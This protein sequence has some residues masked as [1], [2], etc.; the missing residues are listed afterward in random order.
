MGHKRG[1]DASRTPKDEQR[2]PP[3]LFRKLDEMFHFDIDV[4]ATKE[5][6]LCSLYYT[7]ETN[8]L[9][10]PWTFIHWPD[11]YPS[12]DPQVPANPVINAFCNPPYSNG[13]VE[14]FLEKG[15]ME[16]LKGAIVVFLTTSD[17]SPA[18]YDI[19]ALAAEWIAIKGRIEFWHED[20][21]PI[22]GSSMFGSNL[23]V[24]DQEQKV[25]Q[26]GETIVTRMGWK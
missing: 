26:G 24:F 9:Q 25:K 1:L 12:S 21:T 18:Y 5:N 7:K 10:Q 15:Y 8:A 19:C 4:A 23:I 14:A 3:K 11:G 16:S 17:V 6:A 22:K 2:T 20:G 13:M